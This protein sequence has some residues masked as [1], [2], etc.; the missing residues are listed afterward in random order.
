MNVKTVN[1]MKQAINDALAWGMVYGPIIPSHQ[2]DEMRDR[3]VEQH[4]AAI[5]SEEVQT[6][7]MMKATPEDMAIYRR[8]AKPSAP[9]FCR[10]GSHCTCVLEVQ[11][12]CNNWIEQNPPY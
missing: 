8:I 5:A 4:L 2:W 12:R 9:S 6:V 10:E 1:A 3:Q 7:E 11:E